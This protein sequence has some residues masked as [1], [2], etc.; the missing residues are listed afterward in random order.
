[1]SVFAGATEEVMLVNPSGWVGSQTPIFLCYSQT[2][3]CYS[4]LIDS[5]HLVMHVMCDLQRE[6]DGSLVQ[7][8][9]GQLAHKERELQLMK[10]GAGE[11]NTLRQQNYL[12]Q[13]KVLNRSLLFPFNTESHCWQQTNQPS[14]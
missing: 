10:E 12:L 6:E 2:I 9:R 13:I 7:E 8:L 4:T 14:V 5:P 11:I 1:M 3:F